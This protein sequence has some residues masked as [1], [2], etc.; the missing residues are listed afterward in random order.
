MALSLSRHIWMSS[1]S[2]ASED[3]AV[4]GVNK[5]FLQRCDDFSYLL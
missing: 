5:M 2:E 1:N 4:E 3:D